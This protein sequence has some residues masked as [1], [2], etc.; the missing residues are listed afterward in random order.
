MEH[1]A[2]QERMIHDMVR[3][4]AR[5]VPPSVCAAAPPHTLLP[6]SVRQRFVI[7]CVHCRSWTTN[8][9]RVVS[10]GGTFCSRECLWTLR[11]LETDA[12]SPLLPRRQDRA[13][14]YAS[15]E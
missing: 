15:E 2:E 8:A 6:L 9:I 3:A 12:A 11:F 14:E 10:T 5:G 13:Q 4:R 1:L 7:C